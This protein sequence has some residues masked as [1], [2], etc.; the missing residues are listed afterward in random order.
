MSTQKHY[1]EGKSK[2]HNTL[3]RYALQRGLTKTDTAEANVFDAE[4]LSLNGAVAIL[5]DDVFTEETLLTSGH[6]E[7][8]MKQIDKLTMSSRLLT[9]S[10]DSVTQ[11]DD[12]RHTDNS[13]RMVLLIR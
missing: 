6:A 11:L 7:V 2:P 12:F 4:D 13:L 10:H 9:T 3:D 5:P 8:T 1:R